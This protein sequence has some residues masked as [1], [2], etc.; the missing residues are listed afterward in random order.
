M[1]SRSRA[2]S[3]LVF[4]A[5]ILLGVAGRLMPH[6]P[7]FTPVAAVSLF[8]GFYF[9]RR[10]VAL[11]VPL[12]AMLV[13]DA[14]VGFYHW[15]TMITVYAALAAPVLCGPLLKRRLGP[16][17]VLGSSLAG[18]CLF[19]VTT[20]AAVWRFDQMY[21]SGLDGLV[22]CY[23]AALPFFRYTALGDLTWTAVV[24]GAYGCVIAARSDW[25]SRSAAGR[26]VTVAR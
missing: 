16:V 18:S 1:I 19:F 6:L 3:A 12:C 20:N 5:L 7:N 22:Q 13:S 23:T 17:M 8:A 26:S 10:L 11:L 24:F 2:V 14:V 15:P 25:A 21:G 4:V 9:Q